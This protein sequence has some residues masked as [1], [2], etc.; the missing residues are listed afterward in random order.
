M[1]ATLDTFD[2]GAFSRN[3]AADLGVADD[4]IS[5]NVTAASVSVVATI[6]PPSERAAL[7]IADALRAH[8]PLSL[9]AALGVTVASAEPPELIYREPLR[10]NSIEWLRLNAW[11][12]FGG[13]GTNGSAGVSP[14]AWMLRDRAA[15]DSDSR[16]LPSCEGTGVGLRQVPGGRVLREPT[17]LLGALLVL[18]CG[19]LHLATPRLYHTWSS[20]AALLS[21]SPFGWLPRTATDAIGGLIIAAIG[22]AAVC[23][24]TLGFPLFVYV[25]LALGGLFL[26][27]Y[28]EA[29]TRRVQRAP[30]ALRVIGALLVPGGQVMLMH[31]AYGGMPALPD[32]I[33]RHLE[34]VQRWYWPLLVVL[35]TAPIHLVRAPFRKAQP[36]VGFVLLLGGCLALSADRPTCLALEAAVH[37]RFGFRG[38]GLALVGL[39]FSMLALAAQAR[40]GADSD[41]LC[42]ANRYATR[43][44]RREAASGAR[45]DGAGAEA[46][47]RRQ[48]QLDEQARQQQL[49]DRAMAVARAGHGA[50]MPAQPARCQGA[51]GRVDVPVGRPLPPPAGHVG[52]YAGA[53]SGGAEYLTV[54]RV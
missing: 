50:A 46:E 24:A 3:L 31:F 22:A 35:L 10:G 20:F 28:V 13:V 32:E 26:M 9:T 17:T 8:T 47:A 12:W 29:W 7:A 52:G 39:S 25:E 45:R 42:R 40:R 5:L 6:A 30:C 36:L 21:V 14:G 23:D 37:Y 53:P 2:A 34:G 41:Q 38:I 16:L 48:M 44:A 19:L 4:S 49:V 18:I 43:P 33:D 11:W 51:H 27:W 1:A 54:S 15:A